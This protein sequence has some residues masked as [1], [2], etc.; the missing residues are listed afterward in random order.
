MNFV[1][2]NRV[3][4]HFVGGIYDPHPLEMTVWIVQRL[5]PQG[6]VKPPSTNA[7]PSSCP[8]IWDLP[9]NFTYALASPSTH[10]QGT[11]AATSNPQMMMIM[12]ITTKLVK[13]FF[14]C[15]V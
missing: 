9:S 5:D 4:I 14:A 8:M 13:S 12:M 11:M 3:V 6:P 2:D 7:P 15:L 1:N 10:Y